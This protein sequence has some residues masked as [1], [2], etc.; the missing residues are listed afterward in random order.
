MEMEMAGHAGRH[1]AD[2]DGR[3]A[4][5]RRRQTIRRRWRRQRAAAAAG[6]AAATARSSDYKVDGNKVTYSMKCDGEQ[7]MS[8]TGEFVYA[9]DSYTGVMTMDTG[10]RGTMK[11]KYTGKRLGDCVK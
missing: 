5:R 9:A 8:G 7:P 3:S 11:M 10:G 4:S 2:D 6:V 1:A